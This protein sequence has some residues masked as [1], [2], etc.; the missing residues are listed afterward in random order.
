MQTRAAM[1]VELVVAEREG[2]EPSNTFWDVTHFPGERL[3]PLGH[4]STRNPVLETHKTDPLAGRKGTG[5]GPRDQIWGRTPRGRCVAGLLAAGS[6]VGR[7]GL[8][9]RRC[10]EAGVVRS[11]GSAARDPTV[12]MTSAPCVFGVSN[13]AGTFSGGSCTRALIL[14]QADGN[15]RLWRTCDRHSAELPQQA[16]VPLAQSSC[17]QTS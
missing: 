4:L 11:P 6:L 7:R 1:D 14:L 12:G 2:F 9:A 17:A 8:V 15:R 13:P 16:S 5:G 3:R 10:I